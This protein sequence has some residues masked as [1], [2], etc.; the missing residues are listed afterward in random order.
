M[1]LENG[2]IIPPSNL[3]DIPYCE[4]LTV[5]NLLVGLR[6]QK[7]NIAKVD[8]G[9][10][11]FTPIHFNSIDRRD[12]LKKDNKLRKYFDESYSLNKINL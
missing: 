3:T 4:T 5:Q 6:P 1:V 9:P 12:T 7:V 10:F 11:L 8:N 2:T